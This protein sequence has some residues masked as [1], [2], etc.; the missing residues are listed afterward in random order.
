MFNTSSLDLTTLSNDELKALIE[1]AQALIAERNAASGRRMVKFDN[2]RVRTD[3]NSI[4][5]ETPYHPEFIKQARGLNGKFSGGVWTFDVRDAERVHQTVANV[6]GAV[7][8]VPVEVV[9][10]EMELT[11]SNASGQQVFALGRQIASRSM[12]DSRVKLGDGVTVATGSFT[13]S[14][15]S[16]NNPAIMGYRGEPVTVLVRDVP[17]TLAQAAVESDN[18]VYRIV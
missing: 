17:V 14:G 11:S 8:G 4:S 10:V 1:R 18:K 16:R 12:R 5:V 7:G 3:G 6:Y 2:I 15:G 9:D 13:S